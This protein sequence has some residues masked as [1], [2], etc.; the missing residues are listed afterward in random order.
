LEKN[1]FKSTIFFF[2]IFK[3]KVLEIVFVF[4]KHVCREHPEAGIGYAP[5]SSEPSFLL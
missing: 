2:N 1:T 3:I 4:G 5:G